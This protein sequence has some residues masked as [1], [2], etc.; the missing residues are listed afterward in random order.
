MAGRN[1]PELAALLR[2]IEKERADAKR[3][4]SI[5]WGATSLGSPPQYHLND[6]DREFNAKI[7]AAPGIIEAKRRSVRN[8]ENRARLMGSY[9]GLVGSENAYLAR[10][11][12]ST[13]DFNRS[14]GIYDQLTE[15]RQRSHFWDIIKANLPTRYFSF[16]DGRY[17]AA[18]YS[19]REIREMGTAFVL[20]PTHVSFPGLCRIF[21][22][23]CDNERGFELFIKAI[24][25]LNTRYD[26]AR[27]PPPARGAPGPPPVRGAPARGPPP[28]GRR[29]GKSTTRRHKK[30]V[31]RTRRS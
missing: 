17:G 2:K 23:I 12:V 4:A 24:E 28:A 30:S 8:E 31:R 20:N 29:G 18:H 10:K 15:N 16:D 11:N 5:E 3:G 1:D 9:V 27:A 13:D 22:N 6:I 25:V 21:Y 14:V 19:E 26:P 7:A